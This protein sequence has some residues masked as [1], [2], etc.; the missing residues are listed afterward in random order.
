MN[1]A[2]TY[3]WDL[4]DIYPS[5]DAWR[6]A[7]ADVEQRIATISS[8]RG[9]LG[10]NARQLRGCLD[11]VFEIGKQLRR[12][13]AYA[14]MRSDE[15]TRD[16]PSL[17]MRQAAVMLATRFSQETS[18][19]D[20]EILEIGT[21]RVNDFIGREAG[22][23]LYRHLLEDILRRQPHTLGGEAEAVI[24]TAGL[25]ADAPATAYSILA[26]A[27]IPWPTVELNDGTQARLDQAGYSRFRGVP[28]RD[29]RKRVFEAF[30][31]TWQAYQRTCGV[32]LNSQVKRDLFYSQARRYPS[33]LAAA[34]DS[35]HI[36]EAVYTTLIS[37]ANEG[38]PTLHRYFRLRGRMLGVSDLRY[39]DIYPP[40]VTSDRAF[41]IERAQQLVLEALAPLGADYVATVGH[42]F[43]SRWMDVF[44][45]P[46]KRSGAYSSGSVYDEHPFVLMN[47]NDDYE[48]VSTLAHEWGHAMHSQLAN[49]AQPY[50]TAD[51]SI[52]VAEVASTFNEALLLE[53]MLSTAAHDD[54]RLYYLGSALEGLRGTF[55]R[56]TMFAEFELEIHRLV[57][58]GEALSGERF[59]DIY[60]RLLRRY[61]GH[62]EGV[63]RID[64]AYTVEWAYIPH[65][66]SGF[67]VY[68]YATSIAAASLLAAEVLEGR[69]GARARYLGLLEAGGSDYPYELLKRAG[70]DLADGAPYESLI[71]R[72][73]GIMDEIEAILA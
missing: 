68:Q 25:M 14:S 67:Y 43:G 6:A 35:D 54:E 57:E 33:A 24:A 18:F 17:E 44:P 51:Y 48:S 20:P 5:Q 34:L 64:D 9:R 65:F 56:Q 28:E 13:G 63:L 47:Y 31:G 46:G 42:G 36:P 12:V 49:T 72:M 30:W 71:Q 11:T 21:E 69:T 29:D 26:N 7:K 50:P 23:G 66:Y 40:L 19:I 38:L 45:H 52:F 62:E 73:N 70:V 27:E 10:E 1:D 8:F 58:R 37:K 59:S 60:G 32:M 55:F 2:A 16:A 15:D 39:Y 22:L 41:P 53:H 3:S 61:H 4:T